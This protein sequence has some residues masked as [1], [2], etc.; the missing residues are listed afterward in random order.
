MDWAVVG[1][2]Q[3]ESLP[4]EVRY[5]H[6]ENNTAQQMNSYRPGVKQTAEKCDADPKS[7]GNEADVV[8]EQQNTTAVWLQAC[9]ETGGKR[10]S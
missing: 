10:C 3:F 7:Q 2:N 5:V 1:R 8:T 6:Y 9:E 4:H